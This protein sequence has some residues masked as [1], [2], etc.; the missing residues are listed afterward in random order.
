MTPGFVPERIDRIMGGFTI[1]VKALT[2]DTGG[3]MLD[4]HKASVII[5]FI[6]AAA[7][8]CLLAASCLAWAL[9]STAAVHSP[10]YSSSPTATAV[11]C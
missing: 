1:K 9:P 10:P 6:K 4:E 3:T 2:F 11:C 7:W 8:S 5:S